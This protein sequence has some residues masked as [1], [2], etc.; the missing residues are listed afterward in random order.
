[1]TNREKLNRMTNQELAK[2]LDDCC[3]DRCI[4][5]NR[6]CTGFDCVEGIELWLSR[7]INEDNVNEIHE[8]LS[9]KELSVLHCAL[10]EE[11][12][13]CYDLFLRPGEKK[14]WKERVNILYELF[15]K[16][17]ID[18]VEDDEIERI[19]RFVNLYEED[20]E[21]ENNEVKQSD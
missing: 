20:N 6:N 12:R 13:N 18:G 21:V 10:R 17:I 11:T 16:L 5:S 19:Y 2:F 3:T 8:K 14:F 7:E 4:Y 9:Y 1:M 15:K